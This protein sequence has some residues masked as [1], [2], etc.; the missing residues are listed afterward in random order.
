MAYLARTP[1]CRRCPCGVGGKG[2]FYKGRCDQTW[3]RREAPY[4]ALMSPV[5]IA[6]ELE[7]ITVYICCC[8]VMRPRKQVCSGAH[9][10]F[11]GNHTAPID[12]R[13]AHKPARKLL[14][15]ESVTK[16]TPAVA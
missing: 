15:L 13:C 16:R 9:P 6:S 7:L 1:S 10:R 5:P 4:P 8:G 3:R 2:Q 12:T 14:R 11:P